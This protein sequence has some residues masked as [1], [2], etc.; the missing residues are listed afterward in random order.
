MRVRTNSF[1]LK[2]PVEK[3]ETYR[4]LVEEFEKYL[5]W[6]EQSRTLFFVGS[7]SRNISIFGRESRSINRALRPGNLK[8]FSIAKDLC[9]IGPPHTP[10]Y[11]S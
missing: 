2:R 4:A 10:H 7:T 6:V 3:Q 11:F 9:Y 5:N 1:F 8:R